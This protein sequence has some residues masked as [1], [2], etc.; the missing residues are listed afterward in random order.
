L[1]GD[2]VGADELFSRRAGFRRGLADLDPAR[3]AAAARVHLRLDHRDGGA[4]LFGG[5]FSLGRGVGEEALRHG[6]AEF[7]EE[8]FGLILVNIHVFNL[9]DSVFLAVEWRHR[10]P[11]YAAGL[12]PCCK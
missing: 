12:G 11:F 6:D 5:F 7:T 2:E 4:E 1:N 9:S 10:M 8:L 3:L